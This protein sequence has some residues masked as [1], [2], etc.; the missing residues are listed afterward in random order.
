MGVVAFR[1]NSPNIQPEPLTTLFLTFKRA[2]GVA[3]RTI[4]DYKK[5]LGLYFKR[6]PDGLEFPRERTQEFLGSYENPCTFNLYFA[7]L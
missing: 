6:H 7:M 1:K 2:Q 4:G 5:T 3:P